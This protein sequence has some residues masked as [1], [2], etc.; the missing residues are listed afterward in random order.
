MRQTKAFVAVGMAEEATFLA[1]RTRIEDFA[2]ASDDFARHHLDDEFASQSSLGG[3]VVHG[4][5]LL[6]FVSAVSSTL[7][8]TVESH[9]VS[10]G[11]DSVRFRRPALVG[12]E[13]VVRYVVI[14]A[15]PTRGTS[16]AEFEVRGADGRI[17]CAGRH[18]MK[19]I[20]V[21]PVV[22]NAEPNTG[23]A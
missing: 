4:V 13:V 16:T 10:T 1:G 15:D 19:R 6:G 23:Q 17:C 21:N 2:R 14:E 5:L 18:L 12:D 3:A 11:Y 20:P 8:E 22:G 7:L 9:Y